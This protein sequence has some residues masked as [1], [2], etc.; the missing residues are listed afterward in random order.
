VYIAQPPLYQIKH[1]SRR[2]EVFYAYSDPER[3]RVFATFPPER[4]PDVQR[5]KGLGEMDPEQLWV[6]TMDPERRTL[7]LVTLEDLGVAEEVFSV[8]MGDDVESRRGFIES[9]ARY[10][11]VDV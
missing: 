6:T 1:P 9:N 7:K 8:L 5:F 4:K 10:A 2:G 11:T 3:D